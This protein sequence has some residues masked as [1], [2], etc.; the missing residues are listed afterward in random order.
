[1]CYNYKF[2]D[3]WYEYQPVRHCT[4]E[5]PNCDSE[6]YFCD[7]EKWRCRSRIQL[8]GNCTGYIGTDICHKSICIQ[9]FRLN[10][11]KPI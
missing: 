4:R 2:L 11:Q 5:T 3:Y 8:G 10:N 9:V 1:M 7:K 6:Y